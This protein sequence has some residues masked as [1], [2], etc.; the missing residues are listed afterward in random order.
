MIIWCGYKDGGVNVG[1]CKS[2]AISG[3]VCRLGVCR[4]WFFGEYFVYKVVG[5]CCSYISLFC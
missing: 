5:I 1:V 4:M 2:K 3:R